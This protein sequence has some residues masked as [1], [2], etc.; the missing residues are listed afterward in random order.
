MEF[1]YVKFCNGG[2]AQVEFS[3][4][5]L[6]ADVKLNSLTPEAKKF[7]HWT[8][9]QILQDILRTYPFSHLFFILYR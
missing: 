8:E 1:N 7:S 3:D 4:C 2:L 5:S 9:P 6:L